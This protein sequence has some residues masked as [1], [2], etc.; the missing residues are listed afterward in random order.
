MTAIIII[1]NI[2]EDHEKYIVARF[3]E[4]SFWYWGSWDNRADAESAAWEINGFVA[5][6]TE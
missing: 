6:V 3:S 2:P 5:E 1:N 4:G